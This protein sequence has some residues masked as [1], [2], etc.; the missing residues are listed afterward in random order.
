METSAPSV[1]TMDNSNH[2]K[3]A[4]VF[5]REESGLT[6]EEI[7]ACPLACS[8]PTG[9]M[10]PS[11]NLS[12]SVAV[13]GSWL[14]EKISERRNSN[15]NSG[16]EKNMYKTRKEREVL[17]PATLE[18]IEVL[19]AKIFGLMERAGID[20]R[21]SAGGENSGRRRMMAGH[22]RSVLLRARVSESEVRSMHG[23][24]KEVDKR[25]VR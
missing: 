22:I 21:E 18:E 9:T 10:Q 2:N 13:V 24:V 19:V 1:Y 5:G 14:F 3:I 7:S 12:H 17:E 23:L 6:D 4:L 25:V 11:L 15:S 20:A 16:G 8:I